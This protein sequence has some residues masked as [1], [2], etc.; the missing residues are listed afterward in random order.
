MQQ[1]N[2][3]YR[4]L[5]IDDDED[6]YFITSEFMKKIP[7]QK[8]TISWCP[9]YTD[10]LT[11]MKEREFDIYFVDY[12]L[13][14]KTGLDL[15]KEAIR[16]NC[17][18]PIVLLTGRGN[19]EL[20]MESMQS[21]A[22][23]YLVKAELNTEKIERCIRYSLE[24]AAAAK[25]LRD[26]ERKFRSIFEKS[27]D[28][29]FLSD[30]NLFFRDVNDASS[31]LLGFD[32][33]ELLKVSLY[34]LL[35]NKKAAKR[36]EE[37]FD[38]E[39]LVDDLE[40]EIQDKNGS[41]KTCIISI[42][43][44]ADAR[45]NIYVQ[46][47][48]H[49]ITNLKKAEK[50]NLQVQKLGLASRLVR[51]L[52]HEVRNPLNNINLSVEQLIQEERKDASRVYLEIIDRNSQ[53]IG[54]LIDEL[55]NSSKPTSM[56]MTEHALQAV[57]DEAIAAALDRITLKRIKLELSYPNQTLQVRADLKKLKIAFLNIIINAIEAMEEERGSS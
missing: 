56:E 31:Q 50:A 18:E 3:P 27:K 2:L 5:I 40:I 17:E 35:P 14:A 43:K 48:L 32:R 49:D 8:F 52:A 24:R 42:A 55:L 25:A 34:T 4:I 38:S 47:I 22:Y 20:D 37:K 26:N 19:R 57:L 41:N 51:T 6:D 33:D 36:L 23:D 13:G 46:G 7:G 29:V 21:G 16:M 54:D 10:A 39:G 30:E 44:E 28:P 15:L 1:G 12:Y 9:R 11:K 53:R 45:G